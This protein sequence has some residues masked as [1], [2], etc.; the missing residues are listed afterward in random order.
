MPCVLCEKVSQITIYFV[1][2]LSKSPLRIGLFRFYG[3]MLLFHLL[4]VITNIMSYFMTII[5][6]IVG[7]IFFNLSLKY[8][9]ILS[10]FVSLSINILDSQSKIFS[11]IGGLNF[12][13][14]HHIFL[15]TVSIEGLHVRTHLN[16]MDALS[17]KHCHIVEMGCSLLTRAYVPHE[18]W[19]L[20]FATSVHIINRLPTPLINRVSPYEKLIGQSL[21]YSSSTI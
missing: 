10:N 17:E 16:K 2:F 8:C 4:L 18:F 5:A 6:N 1:F 14:Y 13:N 21:D 11:L 7:F 19:D 3:A 15:N 12:K 20:D 9:H